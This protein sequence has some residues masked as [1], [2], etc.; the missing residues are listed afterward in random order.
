MQ[1]STRAT[2]PGDRDAVLALVRR[3]FQGNEQ[4]GQEE[5]DIVLTTWSGGAALAGLDLVAVDGGTIVGHVLGSRAHVGGRPVAAIAP[6]AV[7]PSHQARGIGT[8]LM[9]AVIRAAEDDGQPLLALLG[10]PRYYARFGF[11]PGGSVGIVY[12]PVGPDSPYFQVRRL[13]S[14]DSSW[15]GEFTYCWEEAADEG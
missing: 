6:L 15:R 13:S 1:I 11:E 3:A 5:V 4:R 2:A 7:A 10:N 12:V 14:Y 9:T 8:A